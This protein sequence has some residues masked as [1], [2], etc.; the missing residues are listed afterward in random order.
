MVKLNS[1]VLQ[2]FE[3]NF[4]LAEVSRAFGCALTT[5]HEIQS[6][7]NLQAKEFV[8]AQ[9]L[10]FNYFT[11]K[12]LGNVLDDALKSKLSKHLQAILKKDD[13]LSRYIFPYD[14][15]TLSSGSPLCAIVNDFLVWAMASI[16]PL[17]L[18]FMDS[19]L[20]IGL[21][22]QLLKPTKLMAKCYNSRV[23]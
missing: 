21:K 18:E 19:L 13:S 16:R 14:S 9:E 20:L 23:V 17:N 1:F 12:A 4:Y 10:Y 8:S 5:K 2:D 3:K 22:R 6:N 15:C 11:A 7:L